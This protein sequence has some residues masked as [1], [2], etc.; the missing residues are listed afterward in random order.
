MFYKWDE[1]DEN[2]KNQA[3]ELLCKGDTV[4]TSDYWNLARPTSECPN[5]IA[6]WFLYHAFLAREEMNKQVTWPSDLSQ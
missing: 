4:R 2:L 6:R 5:W 1:F 3:M